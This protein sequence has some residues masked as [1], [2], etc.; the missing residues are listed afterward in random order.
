MAELFYTKTSNI[1]PTDM[2]SSSLHEGDG[3]YIIHL[4]TY[5]YHIHINAKKVAK[6]S[7]SG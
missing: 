2:S 7:I 6:I 1:I 3:F 5:L 4:H